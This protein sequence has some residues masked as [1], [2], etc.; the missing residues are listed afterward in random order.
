MA[1]SISIKEEKYITGRPTVMTPS[2]IG[3]LEE[4]FLKSMT[5][6]EACLYAGISMDTLYNYCNKYPQFSERKEMLKDNVNLQAK[7]NLTESIQ[8]KKNREDSK[9]WLE[10]KNKAE[11]ALRRDISADN[12]GIIMIGN[13]LDMLEDRK[14]EPK[15]PIY[16]QHD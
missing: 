15:L 14:I 6:R 3:K 13:I 4:G 5:D 7:C 16:E 11:F 10:R 9:W 12:G 8:D 2:V 1:K